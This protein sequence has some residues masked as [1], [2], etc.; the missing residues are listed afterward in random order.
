MKILD[1]IKELSQNY[2][3][4]IKL[5]VEPDGIIKIY[6][7]HEQINFITVYE[8]ITENFVCFCLRKCVEIYFR[9]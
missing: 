5:L 7:D 6:V 2:R 8:N 4:P 1:T 9:R 3:V